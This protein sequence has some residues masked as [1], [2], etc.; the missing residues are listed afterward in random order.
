MTTRLFAVTRTRGPAWDPARP[1]EA[2]A[3]WAGH[4]AFIH[5]L[6]AEGFVLLVGPLEDTPDALLIVRARDAQ[7][8]DARLARDCWT[9]LDLLRTT[10]VAP[11]TLRLGSIGS[12]PEA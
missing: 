3:D 10:Q 8:I 9:H 2:Q 11:W 4:A 5:S 12:A 7:E 6:H 1:M